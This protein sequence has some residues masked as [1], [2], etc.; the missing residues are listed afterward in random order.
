LTKTQTADLIAS[1]DIVSIKGRQF[2]SLEA[3]DALDVERP[4]SHAADN[5][6]AHGALT[7]IDLRIETQAKSEL[8]PGTASARARSS[9][10]FTARLLGSM[11]HGCAARSGSGA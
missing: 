10:A 11:A 2:I 3:L 6:G 1:G 8:Y 7:E 9:A 4:A 5:A